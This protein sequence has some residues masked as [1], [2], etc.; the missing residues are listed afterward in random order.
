MNEYVVET[1]SR[2]LV[3]GV[4][5]T[6]LS[7]LKIDDMLDVAADKVLMFASRIILDGNCDGELEFKEGSEWET[8]RNLL[9]HRIE[10]SL[11]VLAGDVIVITLCDLF[12]FLS[13]RSSD[14]V[15]NLITEYMERLYSLRGLT[16]TLGV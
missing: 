2:A 16:K 11:G 8:L 9:N 14:Y 5:E 12:E 6:V 1:A 3:V 7:G 13:G 15:N 10:N 4:A